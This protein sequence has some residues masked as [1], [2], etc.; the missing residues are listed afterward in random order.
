MIKAVQLHTTSVS[1]NTPSAWIR[2]CFTGG[3][4]Y[5]RRGAFAGLIR[6][7]ATFDAVHQ[8][9]GDAAARDG[10]DAEGILED[11]GEDLRNQVEM[12]EDD[13]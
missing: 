9:G 6:E 10:P 7:E 11:K 13:K 4:R 12:P 2:P 5:V 1:V 3:C 8:G